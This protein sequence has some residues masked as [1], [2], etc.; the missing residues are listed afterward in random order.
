MPAKV[1]KTGFDD[2][3]EVLK[4]F[5]TLSIT[6]LGGGAAVPYFAYVA[7]IAPPWPPGI[8]LLTSLTELICIIVTFQFLR[9]KGR[10]VINKVVGI[11]VILLLVT[12]VVYLTTF[13][14]FTYVPPHTSVRSVKGFICRT[15]ILRLYADQCPLVGLDV[16][17]DAQWTAENIWR[18]WSVGIMKVVISSL[19]LLSFILLTGAIG[20]FIVY[21]TK[22]K[23]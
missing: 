20:S 6:A 15:D 14:I 13:A 9:T 1:T 11:T 10:R 2:F 16:L 8:M 22:I 3:L 23:R 12:S 17:S 21:Q 4:K 7:K 19:W 18:E 5:K